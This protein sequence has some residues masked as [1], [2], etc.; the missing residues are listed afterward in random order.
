MELEYN[1]LARGVAPVVW[2]NLNTPVRSKTEC[3]R[4]VT[5]LPVLTV[6]ERHISMFFIIGHQ[7]VHFCLILALRFFFFFFKVDIYIC[8][9]KDK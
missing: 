9:V 1:Q 5:G 3:Q 7:R 2:K 6:R 4:K 8:F